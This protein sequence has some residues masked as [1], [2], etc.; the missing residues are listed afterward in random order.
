MLLT[1]TKNDWGKH[2]TRMTKYHIN[3]S[4]MMHSLFRGSLSV[5]K[6]N[7]DI[8]CYTYT[9]V[10]QKHRTFSLVV[11]CESVAAQIILYLYQK[12]FF[13]ACEAYMQMLSTTISKC[14]FH[15]YCPLSI[16]CLELQLPAPSFLDGGLFQFSHWPCKAIQLKLH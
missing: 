12:R 16:P 4:M 7:R 8:I 13:F 1:V 15:A 3:F 2:K 14:L 11:L 6:W 9:F 5:K 10:I